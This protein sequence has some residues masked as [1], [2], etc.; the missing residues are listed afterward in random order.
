LT[1]LSETLITALLM[2]SFSAAPLFSARARKYSSTIFLLGTGAMI[3]I[4]IFDLTPDVLELGGKTAILPLA[5]AALA[6]SLVHYFHL[7]NHEHEHGVDQ[8]VESGFPYFFG[9]LIAHSFATGMLLSVSQR[10]GHEM[11][12]N[13]FGALLTHKAYE[14]LLLSS[15]LIGMNRSVRWK[16]GMIALYAGILP[17][18]VFLGESVRQEI[19]QTVAVWIS[20]V[21]VGTL[22]GCLVFDFLLPSIHQLQDK[23]SRLIW[24]LSGF[25]L[26][27]LVLG[28]LHVHF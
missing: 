6:Y 22:L 1:L 13:V 8:K 15:I 9:P 12:H 16:V 18:G 25:V 5:M 28:R 20:A 7:F 11:A 23:R 24:V 14:A 27:Q 17:L 3:G 19:S 10:F 4:C 26:T 2:A 21:A